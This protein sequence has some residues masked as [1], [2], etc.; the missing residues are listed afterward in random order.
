[1]IPMT[2]RLAAALIVAAGGL[3]L[4]AGAQADE[5]TVIEL[6]QVGCQFLESENGA[7]HGIHPSSKAEC[8]TFNEATGDDRLAEAK[9]L[10]VSAG[11]YVFRVANQGVPY[12]LGFWLRGDGLISRARLPSVSGGGLADGDSEDFAVTLVPGEYL[13]SCPLNP[14]L[15]Y[16][17]VVDG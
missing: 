9:V 3:T 10:R 14:T 8:E 5:P 13:Y 6:T 1:M 7:N 12:E 16:R 2:T 4:V 17:L 15:D 11:D